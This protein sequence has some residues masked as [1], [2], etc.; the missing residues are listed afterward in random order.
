[1]KK[2]I[3][4]ILGHKGYYFLVQSLGYKF[5]CQRCKKILHIVNKKQK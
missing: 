4:L 5:Y 3:C 1:M 2:L